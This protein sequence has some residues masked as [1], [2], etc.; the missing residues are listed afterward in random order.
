MS[1]RAGAHHEKHPPDGKGLP[2]TNLSM[3][4]QF[5]SCFREIVSE[6][7]VMKRV[8]EM[9]LKVAL[10]DAPVLIVGEPGSGRTSI[11]R[12]IHCVSARRNESFVKIRHAT[13]SI[14]TLES[15]LFGHEGRLEQANKG[16]LLWDEI[17]HVPLDLQ[18]KLLRLL[19]QRE[20]ERLGGTESIQVDVRL[21][22]TTRYDLEDRV[23]A[24][25]F[26]GDLYYHLKVFAIQVPALRERRDDIPALAHYFMQKFARRLNKRIE[27]IPAATMSFLTDF[28][29][30]GNV[31]QL[32]TLIERSVVLT[33]GPAL[34]VPLGGLR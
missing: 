19:Q 20:F 25:M 1:Q 17:A 13:A 30:P 8:L 15:M 31:M 24:G 21:I 7:G 6:S 16:M 5:R 18:A 22:A 23:A 33:E 27:R 26:R 4:E 2:A 28:S 9:A 14:G 32:E 10:T 12:A 3:E 29:W 34:Q 11:A